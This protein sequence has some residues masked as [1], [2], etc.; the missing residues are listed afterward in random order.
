MKNQVARIEASLESIDI[1]VTCILLI[2]CLGLLVG[3]GCFW[4]LQA[5]FWTFCIFLVIA[6]VIWWCR[7]MQAAGETIEH[8][9]LMPP[10]RQEAAD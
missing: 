4:S 3:I 6:L 7:L 1:R 2:T 10:E 8:E 5:M 9:E